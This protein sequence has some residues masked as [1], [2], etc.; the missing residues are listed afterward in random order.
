MRHAIF[1]ENVKEIK[2][3][4]ILYLEG[5]SSFYEGVNDFSDWVSVIYIFNIINFLLLT[6]VI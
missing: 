6:S 2:A 5:K 1:L 4:N 3:H